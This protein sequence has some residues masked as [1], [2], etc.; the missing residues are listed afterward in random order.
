MHVGKSVFF[1]NPDEDRS[2]SALYRHEIALAE[3]AEPLGFESFWIAEHH[4]GGYDVSPN[5]LQLLTYLAAKTKHVRLGSSVVVLPWHDPL[6]VAEEL[7]VL[8]H[9]SN[10]RLLFGI[11]RGLGRHE[12]EGF[13]LNMGESRQRFA[14]YAKGILDAFDT[15]IIESDGELWKQPPVQ[16]RP[17]PLA[18]LR[19]RTYASSVSPESMDI[20]AELGAGI[21]VIAQKPW[22]VTVADV[23]KYNERFVVLNGY[24]PPKPLLM[25]FVIVHESSAA[26]QELHEQYHYRYAKSTFDWYEFSNAGLAKVPGYE[27]YGKFAANIEKHGADNFVKFLAE[28]QVYGTPDEVVEQLTD[29]VRRIDGVG[30]T[31]VLSFAGMSPDIGTANQ[32]LFAEK[33]LPR[34]KSIDPER[35]FPPVAV[36]AHA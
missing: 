18:P 13:R 35:A 10:G 4:F 9:L 8:D 17:Q 27:Y 31:A 23:K 24:E 25:S 5:T 15:G 34:L 22:D 19:N 12:F 14:E 32:K 6:R 7:S 29:H 16:L 1:Q 3:Q 36:P 11:G 20:V 2:D 28:L 21:M 30:M 26:A 33:V